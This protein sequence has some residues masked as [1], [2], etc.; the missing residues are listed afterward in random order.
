MGCSPARSSNWVDHVAFPFPSYTAYTRLFRTDAVQLR[1]AR[2]TEQQWGLT[3]QPQANQLALAS[4][5]DGCAPLPFLTNKDRLRL[6]ARRAISRPSFCVHSSLNSAAG[7][8]PAS[9][10]MINQASDST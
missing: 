1:I 2:R 9:A 6:T 4:F 7:F 3:T 8:E 5:A 10:A